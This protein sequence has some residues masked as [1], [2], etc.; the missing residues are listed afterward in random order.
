MNATTKCP[1][2]GGELDP[3]DIPGLWTCV[4]GC[5]TELTQSQYRRIGAQQEGQ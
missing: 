5:G 1:R 3:A 2:C 4:R